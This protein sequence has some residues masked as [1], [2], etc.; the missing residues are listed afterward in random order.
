M[1]LGNKEI[2]PSWA[3]SYKTWEC[4]KITKVEILFTSVLKA[5]ESLCLCLAIKNSIWEMSPIREIY[6][7]CI[8]NRYFRRHICMVNTMDLSLRYLYKDNLTHVFGKCQFY[9]Y[10]IYVHMTSSLKF[11]NFRAKIKYYSKSSSFAKF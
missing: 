8:L 1:V 9:V 11:T 10:F 6:W 3:Y 4:F 7:I 2:L 5:F